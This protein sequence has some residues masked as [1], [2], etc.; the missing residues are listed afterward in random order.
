ME[1]WRASYAF[2]RYE[3]LLFGTS[4][5]ASASFGRFSAWGNGSLT[6]SMW[7]AKLGVS[8]GRRSMFRGVDMKEMW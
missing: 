8:F 5:V 7:E 6:K 2:L 1:S 3:T 4:M